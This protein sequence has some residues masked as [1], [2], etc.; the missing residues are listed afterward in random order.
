MIWVGSGPIPAMLSEIFLGYGQHTL[1][2]IIWLGNPQSSNKGK[3]KISNINLIFE[4]LHND[5]K[6]EI[7]I[8]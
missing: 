8:Y 4:N 7:S 5:A 1:P 2:T 3:N 6:F